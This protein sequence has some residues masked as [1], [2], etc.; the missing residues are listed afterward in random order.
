[1]ANEKRLIDAKEYC[2]ELYEEM[3]YPGRSE[4]FM[5]AIDVAIAD[6][7]EAPTVDAVELVHGRWED[8]QETEMYVPDMKFTI[9]KTAETC[10]ACKARIVFVGAKRYLFDAICPN[11]GAKMDGDGK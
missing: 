2:K 3:N 9:T 10:S 5:M 1:M 6:L 11:C 8:V 4:E 7:A